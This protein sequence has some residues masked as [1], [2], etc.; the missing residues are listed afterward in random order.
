MI[1]T[2]GEQEESLSEK[3]VG[4]QSAVSYCVLANW[5]MRYYDVS[6]RD[7]ISIVRAGAGAPNPNHQSA[8]LARMRQHAF[9]RRRR[10]PTTPAKHTTYN[11]QH[12]TPN[13]QHTTHNTQHTHITQHPTPN[14]L[15]RSLAQVPFQSEEALRV[16][17]V[18]LLDDDKSKVTDERQRNG[19]EPLILAQGDVKP[20]AMLVYRRSGSQ[21]TL[22]KGGTFARIRGR[23]SRRT[24]PAEAADKAAD[25]QSSSSD[26]DGDED[27]EEHVVGEE[28]F[29]EKREGHRR[30]SLKRKNQSQVQ[31]LP[32]DAAEEVA[33]AQAIQDL[34]RTGDRCAFNSPPLTPSP[35]HPLLTLQIRHPCRAVAELSHTQR[36]ARPCSSDP[37]G[38]RS[39]RGCGSGG[40]GGSPRSRLLLD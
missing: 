25:M 33:F 36:P 26:D 24:P 21:S 38:G 40:D 3:R 14:T 7:L 19:I 2:R 22:L 30:S 27:A 4:T 23:P 16:L 29:Q 32:G 39:S 20:D 15:T 8:H 13:T 5:A 1:C 6:S 11:T 28:E 12:P 37:H 31:V 17:F 34:L 18:S 35:P 9:C 10:T